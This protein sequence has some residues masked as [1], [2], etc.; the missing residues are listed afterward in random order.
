VKVLSQRSE[1]NFRPSPAVENQ[2]AD[3]RY[4][5]QIGAWGVHLADYS[6]RT[7][8]AVKCR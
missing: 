8:R 7:R 4:L 6:D 3:F 5:R 1:R 2:R